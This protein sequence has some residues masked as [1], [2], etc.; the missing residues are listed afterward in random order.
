MN[1][2]AYSKTLNSS[3]L[4]KSVKET[5]DSI[6]NN[7]EQVFNYKNHINGL[8]LGN[9]QSGKTVQMLG[10]IAKIADEGFNIFLLLTT[11]NVYLQKQT[12]ERAKAN[13][14]T[15]EIFGEYDDVAF[16]SS[17]F[18]K[19]I[20]IILKKNTN[21]LKKWRNN[22][23]SSKFCSV[24][25]IVIVDDEA[26]A[27]SLN[28]L[29]NKKNIST[30]NGHLSSI[31]EL[32]NSSIYLQVT[33]TPQAI[34]LQSQVSGWKPEFVTYFHPGQNYI[35]GEFIYSEPKSYCIKF[36]QEKELDDVK[37]ESEFIPLGLRQ[38]VMS[39]LVVC[40]HFLERN[41][42][43]CNFLIHPSVKIADHETFADRIGEHL[44][45]LLS[46]VEEES[47]AKELYEAWKDLQETRPDITNF[48]DI[49][50]NID[51]LLEIIRIIVLNSKTPVGIDYS[52]GFNII[53]GGNS[54]G[55]GITLP[56]LQIVYYC[57]KSKAPQADTFWQHS[58]IFGYD[59][60]AGLLRMYLPPSLHKLFKELN[61][62]N[63][64]LIK[65]VQEYGIAGV[66]LIYPKE[67]KPTRKNIIDKEYLNFIAGGVNFFPNVPIQNFTKIIDELLIDYDSIDKNI[68]PVSLIQE[69]LKYVGS[70]S[71]NDWDNNKFINCV[72]SLSLKRPSINCCLIVR[73]DRD[74]SKGTGTLLSPT[75]RRLGDSMIN[76]LTL[77]MYRV[78]GN[79]EKGWNGS[80][81]WIPNIKFPSDSGF[82]DVE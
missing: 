64:V 61:T 31:K 72:N 33:A 71:E 46:E 17:N 25:P 66:Q 81:F 57:R 47:F 43:T 26:D 5:S 22:L 9:V 80:P 13:L 68:V 39:F 28:T 41:G 4:I 60:D 40:A 56:N 51:S 65:Q 35:G 52:K 14:S 50:R 36:T 55:R 2:T 30:I 75:D 20:L 42:D 10:A 44:N 21:I 69:I 59:R 49:K 53:I 3:P 11:D 15:F 74:I 19:P 70:E 34:L 62:S 48:E 27:A 7:I 6:W 76:A 67:I 23:Y 38:S 37:E 73:R 78:N 32:A 16:L 58:R 54:L 29:I 79:K 1:F 45:F 77:T 12:L 8:L 18:Q 63:T 82:Y 24:N